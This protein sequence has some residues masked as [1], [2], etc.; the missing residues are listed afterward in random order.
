MCFAHYFE[1]AKAHGTAVIIDYIHQAFVDQRAKHIKHSN[2]GLWNG[3][4]Y[5]WA[6]LF[7]K[8]LGY[9]KRPATHKHA[10]A[11]EPVLFIPIQQPVAPVDSCSQ[12]ALTVGQVARPARQKRQPPIEP[13]QEV[14]GRE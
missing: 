10:A 7:V 5:W 1:H 2:A 4:R 13:P 11:F 12:S 8:C 9:L 3:V 14:A 6:Q